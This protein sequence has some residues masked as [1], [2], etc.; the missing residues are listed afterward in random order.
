MTRHEEMKV[1]LENSTFK[2]SGG[3]RGVLVL[4]V[5]VGIVGFVVGA[6]GSQP[7]LAWEALLVNTVFFGG[8]GFG[9]LTFSVIWQITDANWGRPYKRFA[10]AL[11]EPLLK[12]IKNLAGSGK[13]YIFVPAPLSQKRLSQRG[14][15]QA[16]LL[17]KL[18][19]EKTGLEVADILGRRHVKKSQVEVA[20]KEERRNNIKNVFSVSKD[21][22]VPENIILIDDVITTGATVLEATKVLKRAGAKKVVVFAVAMG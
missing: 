16:E 17:A 14:Y 20:D 19:G 10:E 12:L 6:L 8:I 21:A 4:F 22:K 13:G 15:N 9:A 5:A 18:V 7:H 3:L 1:I 2:L 11:A